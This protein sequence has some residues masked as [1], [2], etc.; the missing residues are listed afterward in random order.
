MGVL[1]LVCQDVKGHLIITTQLCESND[2]TRFES[3]LGHNS[4]GWT[5]KGGRALSLGLPS[6]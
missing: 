1:V 6:F 3:A 5:D 4:R 2:V